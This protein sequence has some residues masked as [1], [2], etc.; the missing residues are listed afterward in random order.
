M[1]EKIVDLQPLLFEQLKNH[2]PNNISLVNVL[3][4]LLN[5]SND[6]VYRR[7]RGEK[8]LNLEEL[9]K[10]CV[11]FN[12][13]FVALVGAKRQGL[14]FAYVHLDLTK[15]NVYKQYMKE[16]LLNCSS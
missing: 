2:A 14:H 13:S 15:V 1:E 11:H 9:A 10:I 8:K 5:I 3:S 6:A 7:L 16:L 4:D 12:I